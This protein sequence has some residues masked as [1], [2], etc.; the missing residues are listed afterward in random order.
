MEFVSENGNKYAIGYPKS[1][2][3]TKENL[4]SHFNKVD[5][6]SLENSS[7]FKSIN[8]KVNENGYVSAEAQRIGLTFA[9]VT[10]TNTSVYDYK[11]LF[12]NNKAWGFHF[13]DESNDVYF[14]STF[15]NCSHTVSYNSK[16]PTMIGVK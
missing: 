11:L 15:K 10:S 1:E 5:E 14:C 2:G 13:K 16:K 9:N 6:K 3:Y 4:E 8:L 7:S 12:V